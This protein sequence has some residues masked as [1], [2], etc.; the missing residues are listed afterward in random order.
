MPDGH[1]DATPQD[2]YASVIALRLTSL[3]T[4][5]AA[6]VAGAPQHLAHTSWALAADMLAAWPAVQTSSGLLEQWEQLL[7]AAALLLRACSVSSSAQS[8]PLVCAAGP[9]CHTVPWM[10]ACG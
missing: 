1:L 6:G 10:H 2:E 3:M 5:C 8:T 9:T 7:P 4:G